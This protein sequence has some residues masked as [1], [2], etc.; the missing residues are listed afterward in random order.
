MWAPWGACPG[1][2]HQPGCSRASR[3][4]AEPRED[5]RA[6]QRG[7]AWAEP[8]G[9]ARADQRGV[10]WVQRR[11]LAE[12][13]A[14]LCGAAGGGLE[15]A[16]GRRGGGGEEGEGGRREGRLGG[17]RVVGREGGVGGKGDRSL[18]V[19]VWASQPRGDGSRGTQGGGRGT[20]S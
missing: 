16:G 9:D 3:A 14:V 15:P 2:R 7:V 4:W 6:D 17:G 10:A 8:R 13:C 12:V 11:G 18:A 5:T 19:R 20:G 1:R